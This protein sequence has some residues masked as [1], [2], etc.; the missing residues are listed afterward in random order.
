MAPDEYVRVPMCVR[1][2]DALLWPVGCRRRTC[3]IPDTTAQ[4]SGFD[5]DPNVTDLK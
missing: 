4:G 5:H 1:W 3:V 2:K